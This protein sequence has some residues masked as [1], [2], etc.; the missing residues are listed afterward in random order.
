M[1]DTALIKEFITEHK[2]KGHVIKIRCDNEH[3]FYDNADTRYNAPL[4]WDWA[5][6]CFYALRHN[7]EL[8]DSQMS[9]PF[10]ITLVDF[11]QIQDMQA[12]AP[13]NYILDF[14]NKKYTD[15][16]EKA[17]VTK[18]IQ[19]ASTSTQWLGRAR[20]T[21]PAH[22]LGNKGNIRVEQDTLYGHDSTK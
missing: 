6:E 4:V 2:A 8:G 3:I 12:Y 19:R 15:A 1:D 22:D 10:S 14:V 17:A 5:K 18:F 20:C 13:M 16:K 21:N 9:T 7:D 11:H